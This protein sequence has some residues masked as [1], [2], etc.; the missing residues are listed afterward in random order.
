MQALEDF[1]RGIAA[2][3]PAGAG[4]RALLRS[5]GTALLSFAGGGEQGTG[6]TASID[7]SKQPL[8]LTYANGLVDLL[9]A[10]ALARMVEEGLTLG[11]G[12]PLSVGHGCVR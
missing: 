8:P 10:C 9:L 3:L 5:N 1:A 12:S 7:L 6:A 4:F 11:S 2:K